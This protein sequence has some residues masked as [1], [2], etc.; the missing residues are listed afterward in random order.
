MALRSNDGNFRSVQNGAIRGR[1]VTLEEEVSRGNAVGEGSVSGA[2][3]DI[4]PFAEI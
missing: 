2:L 4:S 1:G 3:K